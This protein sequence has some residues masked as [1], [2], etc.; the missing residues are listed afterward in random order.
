MPSSVMSIKDILKSSFSRFQHGVL[1]IQAERD[2]KNRAGEDLPPVLPNQLVKVTGRDFINIV[3]WHRPHLE[4]FW[5]PISIDKIESQHKKLLV[6]YHSE[7]LLKSAINNC[8][9]NTTFDVGW[10][11]VEGRFD[12][13]KDFCG[14][15]ASVFANTATVE[16]DFSSMM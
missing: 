12:I 4:K 3:S 1:D 16:S 5:E 6:A 14:G 10:G 2:S 13:L 7:P 8:D 9:K 15:I 11:I